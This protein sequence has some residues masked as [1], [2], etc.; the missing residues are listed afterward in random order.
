MFEVTRN[1]GSWPREAMTYVNELPATGSS[2]DHCTKE[3]MHEPRLVNSIP[4]M[5]SQRITQHVH[6]AFKQ[7]ALSTPLNI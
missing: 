1:A 4:T 2:V 3:H 7:V 6:E 5:P